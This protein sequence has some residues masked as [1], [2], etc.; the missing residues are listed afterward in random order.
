MQKLKLC[1]IG[2]SSIGRR[3][4]PLLR[5]RSDVMVC[6]AEPCAP[7]REHIVSEY[8]DIKCYPVM[9]EAIAA[10]YGFQY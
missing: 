8:P 3:H 9:E 5:E 2:A 10:R 4:L 6:V 1:L 7:S